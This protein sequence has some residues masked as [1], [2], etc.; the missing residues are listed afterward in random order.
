MQQASSANAGASVPRWDRARPRGRA[1]QAGA[2]RG[3]PWQPNLQV[4]KDE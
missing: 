2:Q 3:G 1:G 4:C